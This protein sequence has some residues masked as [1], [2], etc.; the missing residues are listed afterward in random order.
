[1]TTVCGAKVASTGEECNYQRMPPVILRIT[2]WLHTHG[3]VMSQGQNLSPTSL[4]S[5]VFQCS[6]HDCG[7]SDR[8]W[9]C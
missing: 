6:F 3:T 5:V 8:I 2:L 4:P 7:Y 9:F 1:M